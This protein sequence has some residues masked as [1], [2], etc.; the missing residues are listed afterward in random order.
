MGIKALFDKLSDIEWQLRLSQKDAL[1]TDECARFLGI[2]AGH[3]R[4]MVA[5]REIP[6]YK[7]GGKLFFSKKEL[8]AWKLAER[9]PTN[10]ELAEIART[11]Y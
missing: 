9:I 4:H 10:S 11:F 6:Y 7:R 8:D 5:A 2:S 3:I 1:N